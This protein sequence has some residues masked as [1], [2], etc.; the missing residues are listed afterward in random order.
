MH[1]L[2]SLSFLEDT[3]ERIDLHGRPVIEIDKD[4]L[5]DEDGKP[6]CRRIVIPEKHPPDTDLIL[7]EVPRIHEEG[8]KEPVLRVAPQET[9][10]INI[11]LSRKIAGQ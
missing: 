11:G 2:S 10:L 4:I 5:M 1:L 3:I 9:V 6:E 7:A 8:L